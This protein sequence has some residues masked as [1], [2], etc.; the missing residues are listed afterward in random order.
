M[1][2]GVM[3]A[4]RLTVLGS[5]L[6]RCTALSPVSSS[7]EWH[8]FVDR[9]APFTSSYVDNATSCRQSK[10][11]V[12]LP[13]IYPKLVSRASL[14]APRWILLTAEGPRCPLVGARW[15]CSAA[16]L[17]GGMRFLPEHTSTRPRLTSLSTSESNRRTAQPARRPEGQAAS[18][19]FCGHT[20]LFVCA[21]ALSFA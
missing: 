14:L 20:T 18:D 1:A 12:R 6:R 17:C 2:V 4:F 8:H 19:F 16:V 10:S 3:A 21:R 13:L 11:I 5:M 7:F 9:S 15:I